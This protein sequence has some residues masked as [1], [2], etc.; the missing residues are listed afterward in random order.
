MP[1]EKEEPGT[2]TFSA[3]NGMLDSLDGIVSSVQQET[4]AG[5]APEEDDI[6]VDTLGDIPEN[7]AMQAGQEEDSLGFMDS[8]DS[9]V[10]EVSAAGEPLLSGGRRACA[11]AAGGGTLWNRP[12][13][14]SQGV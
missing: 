6:M 12:R 5:Q 14:R 1:E 10:D 9:L 4:D 3:E 8:L 7:R 11:G 13:N 2:G